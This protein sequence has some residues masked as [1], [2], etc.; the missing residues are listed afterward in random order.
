[1][2]E[3]NGELLVQSNGFDSPKEAGQLIAVLKRAEVADALETTS[4]NVLVPVEQVLA[5]LARLRASSD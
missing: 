2:L 5:A 3:G 4:I 1:M